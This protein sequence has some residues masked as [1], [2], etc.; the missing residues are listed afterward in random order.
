VLVAL[1]LTKAGYGTP[2]QI[3]KM[4]S[5]IVLTAVEYE[6]YLGEYEEKFLE[7]NRES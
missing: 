2:Q 1:Q 6:K 4:D 3:L 7:L 5:E